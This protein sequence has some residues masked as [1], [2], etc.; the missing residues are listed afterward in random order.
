KKRFCSPTEASIGNFRFE[1]IEDNEEK[2]EGAGGGGGGGGRWRRRKFSFVCWLAPKRK[3][4]TAAAPARAEPHRAIDCC[5][6]VTPNPPPLTQQELCI[7]P[8]AAS[9]R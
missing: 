2:K 5:S 6:P 1:R 4:S 8:S 3:L 7:P 9:I